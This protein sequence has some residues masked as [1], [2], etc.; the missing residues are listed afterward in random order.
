VANQPVEITRADDCHV[1]GMIIADYPGSKGQAFVQ[2]AR[3]PLKFCSTAD[4]FAYLL[5]PEAAAVVREVYVH[6]MAATDWHN[7]AIEAFI[8]ARTAWYVVG[9]SLPGAMGHTLAAFRQEAG[10]RFFAREYGGEVLH[11]DEVTL[12]VIAG[13]AGM[14]GE[15]DGYGYVP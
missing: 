2:G 7:P 10:A 11:F 12:D 9:H 6:D 15:H 13:L 14:Y 5:Q 4:M 8:D 1:C 3:Q